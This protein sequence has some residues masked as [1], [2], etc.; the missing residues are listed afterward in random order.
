MCLPVRYCMPGAPCK[1][2]GCGFLR[3][4]KGWHPMAL[5]VAA[6]TYG[7]TD[8]CP[9]LNAT[10]V[11]RNESRAAPRAAASHGKQHGRHAGR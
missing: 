3:K 7:H 10:G 1:W 11:P 4:N 9:L 8:G 2:E 6:A 5:K